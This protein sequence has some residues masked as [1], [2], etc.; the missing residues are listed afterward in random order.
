MSETNTDSVEQEVTVSRPLSEGVKLKIEAMQDEFKAMNQKSKYVDQ[1]IIEN[2]DTISEYIYGTYR[3][4][5]EKLLNKVTPVADWRTEELLRLKKALT[6]NKQDLITGFEEVYKRN[7]ESS[8]I[9]EYDLVLDELENTLAN[10][11]YWIREKVDTPLVFSLNSETYIYNEPLGLALI[12]GEW[13]SP[14]LSLLKPAI[15]AIAAGNFVI[16]YSDPYVKK[17]TDVLNNVLTRHMDEKRIQIITD[18]TS[19]EKLLE[20]PINFV[21]AA[22]SPDRCKEIFTLAGERRI[23]SAFNKRGLN[24]AV[25]H[26]TADIDRAAEKIVLGRFINAGQYN[27]SPDHV[28]VH[29]SLFDDFV[30]KS[31]IHVFCNFSEPHKNRDY[32]RLL[33]KDHVK[34]MVDL[35]TNENHGGKLEVRVHYD[36]EQNLLEPIIITDPYE[37]SALVSAPV[38]GPILTLLKYKNLD[39]VIN[40]INTRSNVYNTYFFADS[41]QQERKFVSKVSNSNVFINQATTQAFNFNLPVGS[42]GGGFDSK[43]GGRYGLKTFSKS[44]VTMQGRLRQA[45]YLVPPL[46]LDSYKELHRLD[47]LK[48][49]TNRQAKIATGVAMFLLGFGLGSR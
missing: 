42:V 22:G 36:A 30:I 4:L 7:V 32:G 8:L 46:T 40:K 16:L 34:T 24:V 14:L 6:E 5:E 1:K 11:K 3:G 27:T 48:K 21:Y 33:S 28:Y 41:F 39:E 43:I 10:Y 19:Y 20:L 25:V 45:R 47:F 37:K 29:E 35:A 44:R 9:Y 12:I 17:F 13:Q 18:K 49:F 26:P 38:R 31:K 15:N 23:P 2:S